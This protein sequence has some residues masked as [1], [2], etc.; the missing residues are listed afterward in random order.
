MKKIM[1]TLLCLAFFIVAFLGNSYAQTNTADPSIKLRNDRLIEIV[2]RHEVK[3]GQSLSLTTAG[4]EKRRDSN[5]CGKHA[6]LCEGGKQCL[7]LVNSGKC[8]SDTFHCAGPPPTCVCEK[9]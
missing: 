9:N 7:S 6:C 8:N 4:R 2:R 5:G 1:F 3:P